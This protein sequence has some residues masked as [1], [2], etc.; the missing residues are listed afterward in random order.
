MLCLF[1]VAGKLEFRG[2]EELFGATRVYPED[3]D[4]MR[5]DSTFLDK[6]RREGDPEADLLIKE[7]MD[8]DLTRQFYSYLSLS[9]E[10][11]RQN[12]SLELVREFL[13][14]PARI[15]SWYDD[16]R[17]QNGQRFFQK[18]A[19]DVMGLLGAMSLPY[20]YAATPGNKAI[21]FT[22]K[23]K[24]SPGK[25]L[26]DTA[27]FIIEV[28]KDGAFTAHGNG[29]FE[30]QKTRLIHALVRHYIQYK[31]PWDPIWGMPVNQE[32][33]AG[34]NLAFSYII[35][36]GMRQ[37]D[38]ALSAEDENDFLY[39]WRFIGYQLRIDEDL[40]PGNME[41]AKVLEE[42][43]RA[44]HFRKS[45]EGP[46]L[47]SELVNHYKESFPKI[48]SYFVESQIRYFIGPEVSELLGL[49]SQPR[50]DKIVAFI[51]K[52]RRGINRNF[53]NPFS[54][55]IMISN[56]FKLKKKYSP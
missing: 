21:Y 55:R 48:A 27:H 49:K 13:F 45:E 10:Q 14:R 25:R 8:R 41:E 3:V 34:T 29:A 38:F 43:I 4:Y 51:N 19:L 33:M 6:K 9:N 15:P 24:K 47:T 22:E 36:M 30:V 18:Y 17:L 26:L 2:S 50:K 7:V 54:Y 31:T 46:K 39:A 56:H 32:D 1:S 16:A 44:R 42:T 40:L 37:S 23:M 20:C 53:V 11:A 52:V 35:L 12:D 5:S 28:M